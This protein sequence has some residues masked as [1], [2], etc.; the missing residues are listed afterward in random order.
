MLLTKPNPQFQ[1]GIPRFRKC[2]RSLYGAN[3]QVN[4]KKVFKADVGF[5]LRTVSNMFL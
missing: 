2:F 3:S 4:T 1:R 5:A